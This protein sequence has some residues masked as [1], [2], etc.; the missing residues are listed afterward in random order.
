MNDVP[1][2]AI[3]CPRCGG[4]GVVAKIIDWQTQAVD[5]KRC[6]GDG[7]VVLESLTPHERKIWRQ[8]ERRKAKRGEGER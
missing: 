6:D 8:R 7:W 1:D 4:F 3:E 2:G 5:C